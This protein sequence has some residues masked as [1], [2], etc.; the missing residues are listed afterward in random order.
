MTSS[1]SIFPVLRRYTSLPSAL[2]VLAHKKITLLSPSLWDDRNDAFYMRQYKERKKL[3][4]ILA[5]CFAEADETYHH[6][7]VFTYGADGVCIVFKR[8]GLLQAFEGKGGVH[9][10]KVDYKKISELKNFHPPIM[11]LPFLKRHPYR[12]EK[13]YRIVFESKSE[14]VE[15]KSFKINLDCIER[16]TLSPWLPAALGDAVKSIIRSAD[17]C[18]S[19]RVYQSTLLENEKWK[20]GAMRQPKQALARLTR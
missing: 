16:I 18:T 19:M 11:Q 9:K 10:K 15:V 7:R 4:T 17:G 6:W 3:K 14:E 13:E 12:D 2:H 20:K 5:L 1:D 8:D